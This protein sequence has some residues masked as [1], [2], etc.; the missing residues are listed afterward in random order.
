MMM[1]E[2][3]A[4]VLLSSNARAGVPSAKM[5]FPLPSRTG[6]TSSTISSA[7]P[8]SSSVDVSVELP[9]RIR[10]GPSCDL[11]R[12]MPSTRFG[13]TPSNGPH[14]RL[15]GRWV[16]DV[17]LRGVEAV[18]H[19]TARGLRPEARLAIVGVTAKQQTEALAIHREEDIPASG[20]PIGRA[21]IAVG[22]IVVIGGL[23]DHAVQRDVFENSE[24]SHC[25]S[26]I[27]P[28]ASLL[29]TAHQRTTS[30]PF[31]YLRRGV[32]FQKMGVPRP[33]HGTRPQPCAPTPQPLP[34]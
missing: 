5:R 27:Q 21:P 13:P 31:T 17:F 10:S 8:C 34:G 15:S 29:R 7:R 20:S 19:R 16:A 6:L 22:E 1:P 4:F 25:V 32:P 30:V 11:M 18:S 9:E 28:C 14:A 3:K 23:L 2:G 33:V 12:R 24:L 26:L